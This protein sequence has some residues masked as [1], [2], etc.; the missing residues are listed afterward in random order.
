MEV[1]TSI[2]NKLAFIYD[3]YDGNYLTSF[4]Q[5]TRKSITIEYQIKITNTHVYIG[6][7]YKNWMIPIVYLRHLKTVVFIV[8]VK[9]LASINQLADT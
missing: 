8:C 4:G 1:Q 3:T 2:F 7:I 5:G 6:N 9:L